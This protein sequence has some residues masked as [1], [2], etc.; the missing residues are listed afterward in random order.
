MSEPAS[1]SLGI[2]SRYASALFD[3]ARDDK[4]LKALE[5]DIAALSETL[6]SSADL[7]AVVASPIVSREDQGK[8]IAAIGAVFYAEPVQTTLF[9]G[10]GLIFLG[11]W[12]NLR[13]GASGPQATGVTKP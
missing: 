10:A 4:A 12:V 5:A 2:A 6:A 9:L 7:R 1:I 3:L 13:S 8:V 11:I